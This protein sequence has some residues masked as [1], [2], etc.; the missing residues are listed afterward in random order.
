ME[1][2]KADYLGEEQLENLGE[3]E[4]E[5]EEPVTGQKKIHKF[6]SDLGERDEYVAC[7]ASA[8]ALEMTD[9]ASREAEF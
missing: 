8:L 9:E 5:E 2:T 1:K 3:E 6:R 4:E 7:P